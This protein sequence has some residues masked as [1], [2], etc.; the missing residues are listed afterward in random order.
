MVKDTMA[1]FEVGFCEEN[2]I[3][4]GSVISRDSVRVSVC[5]GPN[6]IADAITVA[7]RF[8]AISKPK[9]VQLIAYSCTLRA[10]FHED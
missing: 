5:I 3:R 9:D 8:A 1:V 7:S 10:L 6:M 4:D 2:D